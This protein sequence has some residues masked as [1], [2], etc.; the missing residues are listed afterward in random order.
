MRGSIDR[1]PLTRRAAGRV[2]VLLAGIALATAGCTSAATPTPTASP[3]GAVATPAAAL[4]ADESLPAATAEALTSADPGG[5][6]GSAPPDASEPVATP[7][8]PVTPESVGCEE[9]PDG[10]IGDVETPYTCADSGL[11]PD[12][13]GYSFEN[14]GDPVSGEAVDAS[15]LVR[16]FGADEVCVDPAAA[17]CEL[18]PAAQQWA[19]QVADEIKGGHCEGMSVGALL[20]YA[21]TKALHEID[22]D[23]AVTSD[24]EQTNHGAVE[25]IVYWWTTQEMP[26]VAKV[27]EASRDL[28]PSRIVYDIA[29]GIRDGRNDTLGMYFTDGA[30]AVSPFAV[31]YDGESYTMWVYDSNN[32]G[33]PGRLVVDPEAESWAYYPALDG[34]ADWTGQG[35]GTLDYTPMSARLQDFTA[36]FSDKPRAD[37]YAWTISADSPDGNASVDFVVRS[38]GLTTDT[39]AGAVSTDSLLA[40]RITEDGTGYG[41]VLYLKPA[42]DL[43]VT[44]TVNRSAYLEMAVDGTGIP[45]T[46][47]S[48]KGPSGGSGHASPVSLDLSRENTLVIT[49]P[50]GAIATIEVDT[51]G[52][53]PQTIS[54]N[55]PTTL[56]ITLDP[57]TG[58]VSID[59]K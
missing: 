40:E 30:H 36:P 46:A 53:A 58:E 7:V 51:G 22:P 39:A 29:A 41:T 26:E 12:P 55:G 56:R 47:I 20:Y 27:A 49:L 42:S 6:E 43:T 10:S 44:P 2:V 16:L 4:P 32:P 59:R 3:L 5:P 33:V 34:A 50:S 38:G 14:W 25:D 54:L 15:V 48:A 24:I 52:P 21:D 18:Q 1:R 35:P 17:T 28:P 9:T 23:A 8:V 13:N 57:A 37:G 45:W 31:T 19:Q 11:R